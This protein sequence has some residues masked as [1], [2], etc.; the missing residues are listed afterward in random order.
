MVITT[1]SIGGVTDYVISEMKVTNDLSG[2]NSTAEIL[3]FIVS[4][5]FVYDGDTS[6]YDAATYGDPLPR[7]LDEII[8][9][10]SDGDKVF[11]GFVTSVSRERI[12]RNG[13]LYKLSA[14]DYN[15]LLETTLASSLHTSVSDRVIMQTEFGANLPEIDTSSANLEII[16]SS[17][18]TFDAVNLS[19]AEMMRRLVDLT[20]GEYRVNY[21][22]ELHYFTPGNNLA[23]FQLSDKPHGE[24]LLQFSEEFGVV[25]LSPATSLGTA[26]AGTN[27]TDPTNALSSDDAHAV[28]N[29][30]TQDDLIVT[31]YSNVVPSRATI[32]G[33][34][35][36]VEGNGASGTAAQRQIQLGLTKDGSALAGA[37]NT[38]VQLPQT[39]DAEVTSGSS[40][41]LWGT[42]WTPAELNAST[43]GVMLRDNDVTAAALNI[44]AVTV[45]VY[46]RLWN[47][48]NVIIADNDH[49]SPGP[50]RAVL[51]D[52]LEETTGT[53]FHYVAQALASGSVTSGQP[54]TLSCFV[55]PS[56]RTVVVLRLDD[57][58]AYFDLST[59]TV[60]TTDGLI[61]G[62]SIEALEDG[63]YR[64]SATALAIA[65]SMAV[66]IGC[67]ESDNVSSYTGVLASGLHLWGAQLTQASAVERYGITRKVAAA[68]AEHYKFSDFASQFFNP[69]NSIQVRGTTDSGGTEIV[70]TRTDPDSISTYS[71][72][73]EAVITNRT[74]TNTTVAGLY[75]DVQ[76]L[77]RANPQQRGSLE[78][79]VDGLEVGQQVKITNSAHKLDQTPFTIRRLV[80][81]QDGPSTTL[82]KIDVGPV[83]SDLIRLIQQINRVAVPD[84]V[85]PTAIPPPL[86]VGSDELQT[87]AVI[88]LKIAAGAVEEAK[89]A[90]GAV[91]E[92]ILA[93]AAVTETKIGPDAVTTPKIVAGAVKAAQIDA[94]A[95]VAGKIAAGVITGVE[96]QA[97]SITAIDAVFATGAILSADIGTAEIKTANID[98]LAVTDAK[99]NTLQASKITTGNLAADVAVLGSV[100]ASQIQAGSIAADVAVLGTVQASQIQAGSI[101]AD[102]AV[103]GSVVASQIQ[104]G[105]IAADVAV[106]GTVVASQ[107]QAGTISSVNM[108]AGTFLLSSGGVTTT[109]TA[110]TGFYT[111]ND[112]VN[113][114]AQMV[115]GQLTLGD[116]DTNNKVNSAAAGTAYLNSSGNTVVDI[117]N[118]NDD[119]GQA[120]SGFIAVANSFGS[121]KV[122]LGVDGGDNGFIKVTN[123]T[124]SES[125]TIGSDA[126][127]G[128]ADSGYIAV[129]NA[130]GT[131]KAEM[132]VLSGGNDGKIAST[133]TALADVIA[134]IDISHFVL[135]RASS[136]AASCGLY[137]NNIQVVGPQ[138]IDPGASPTTEQLRQILLTHG[139]I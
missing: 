138:G 91:T 68:R 56:E 29:T 84:P 45:K 109:I 21:D 24:N 86:S 42:T 131:I 128:Q 100:V 55:R 125:V 74:I 30:T 12:D 76:L 83:K 75:G 44:D 53:G 79:D 6:L 47:P 72:T 101:A 58:E 37:R 20:G 35:V 67:A 34:E 19:L 89:L 15:L 110:S 70:V 95:I 13:V 3:V 82:Y 28:Y 51:A 27:W 31:A 112:A 97:G 63:Y 92:S 88:A 49:A 121:R 5:G 114:F 11:G 61:T 41:F 38:G 127:L 103:L 78:T 123:D 36:I 52:K 85:F 10:N 9:T 120:N 40:S 48:T 50:R 81:Q 33:I 18:D 113:T 4:A 117:A 119:L 43:F 126:N 115:G 16:Q 94:G 22:K 7:D 66:E 99:I 105:S 93:A 106:L 90:V 122:Q 107:I 17:I 135:A 2:R 64:C 59:G 80:Q 77:Q 65:T 73:M 118:D 23:A 98:A 137:V 1:V 57:T 26:A 71:R 133:G 104:A 130:A 111:E 54:Y 60:G 62:T 132:G 46:Y 8:V 87:D 136:T 108:Q 134:F 25:S 139:L 124:G 32:L 69:A 116:T 96:I 129:R 14:K 39:T 102:V